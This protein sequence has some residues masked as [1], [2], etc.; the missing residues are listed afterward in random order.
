MLS[1]KHEI[2]SEEEYL[3]M[4]LDN[5]ARHE[6]VAGEVFA[7]TGTT[8]RHNIIAG[9]LFAAL[10]AHLRATPCRVFMADVR[11]RVEKANAHYYADILVSCGPGVQKIDLQT[12][13]VDDPSLIIEVLSTH[14]EAT[15]RREKLL[16]YRTLPSLKEYVLVSQNEA[17][18][19]IHRRL[20]ESGWE[21]IEYS[22]PEVV[23]FASVDLRLDM[24]EIYEGRTH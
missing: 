10:R 15:D 20:P 11:V 16:A 2:L 1:R 13:A 18:V 4:E 9:N 7:M 12:R 19:E 8:L 22:G 17:R 6:Y 23:E 14:T 21:N 3:R 5:P 24:R